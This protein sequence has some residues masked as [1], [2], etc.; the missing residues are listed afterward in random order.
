MNLFQNDQNLNWFAFETR[1]R[2]LIQD[3]VNPIADQV[4][5]DKNNRLQLI[6]MME[7]IQIKFNQ[8]KDF[9]ARVRN[10]S[11]EIKD[12]KEILREFKEILRARENYM[13]QEF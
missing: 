10:N 13:E 3:L 12:L 6:S 7:E 5:S 8:M 9:E 11:E 2:G 1:V 4:Q